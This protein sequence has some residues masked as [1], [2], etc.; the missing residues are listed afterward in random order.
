MLK[1]NTA[2]TVEQ[3]ERGVLVWTSPLGRVYT[4]KPP[5]TL[6]FIPTRC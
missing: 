5:P 6:R 4:D 2:W 1:H 3:H